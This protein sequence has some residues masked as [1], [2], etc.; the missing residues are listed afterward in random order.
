MRNVQN[1][2]RHQ[3]DILSVVGTSPSSFW[4]RILFKDVQTLRLSDGTRIY[5]NS[6]EKDR[7]HQ[8]AEAHEVTLQ[9]IPGL[10]EM[11][12]QYKAG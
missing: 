8:L 5:L 10:S 9:L 7:Y 6:E 11:R 2:G 12:R 3:I 4:R 1:V